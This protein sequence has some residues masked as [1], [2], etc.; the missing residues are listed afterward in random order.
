LFV[1]MCIS[2]WI[3]KL[4]ERERER[5]RE[6]NIYPLMNDDYKEAPL[7]SPIIMN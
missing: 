4:L 2:I 5:E 6:R 3:A 7:S 1:G